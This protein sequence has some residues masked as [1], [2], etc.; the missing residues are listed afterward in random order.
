MTDEEQNIIEVIKSA[1]KIQE[2]LW[3]DMN[4]DC[5]LEEFKRMFRKRVAKI[6]NITMSN[7]HWEVELRKRLLQTAAIAV[8]L[9]TKI[10]NNELKHEGIHPIKCSNLPEYS[11]L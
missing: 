2:F 1:R 8:N 10:E 4:Q 5:G 3:N 11:K 7:P 6:D 9:I